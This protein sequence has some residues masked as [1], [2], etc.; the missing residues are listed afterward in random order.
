MLERLHKDIVSLWYTSDGNDPRLEES[1]RQKLGEDA[2]IYVNESM[3][4]KVTAQFQDNSYSD[5]TQQRYEVA[6]NEQPESFNGAL[7]AQS[8]FALL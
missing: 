8:Y 2:Y 3:T 7:S 6:G 4:V 5:L 1:S